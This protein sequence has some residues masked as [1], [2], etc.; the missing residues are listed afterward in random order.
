[1]DYVLQMPATA[2]FSMLKHGRLIRA[3]HLAELCD[4]QA[5][6]ICNHKYQEHL[7]NHY[8]A[9]SI[10]REAIVKPA[11]LR[12]AIEADSTDAHNLIVGL[13]RAKKGQ[14]H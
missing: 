7:K 4:I 9:L 11:E 12:P 5:V 1:M 6:S 8:V 2:F 14:V 10:D 3:R 13:F